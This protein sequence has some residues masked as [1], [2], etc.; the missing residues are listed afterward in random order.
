MQAQTIKEIIRGKNGE[1]QGIAV[2]TVQGNKSVTVYKDK[3]G[4]ITGRS[5]STTNSQERPIRSI[6]INMGS[7]RV[8]VPLGKLAI[9]PLQPIR[10]SMEE[11]KSE[12]TV[13]G[14]SLHE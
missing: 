1:L 12:E 3:Y 9:P 10:I 7:V 13:R 8:Q 5:E 6:V 11:S 14:S 2:T 4:K